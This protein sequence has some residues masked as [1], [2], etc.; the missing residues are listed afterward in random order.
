MD[1]LAKE[2]VELVFKVF[3]LNS[4]NYFEKIWEMRRGD[5]QV[6]DMIGWPMFRVDTKIT[7]IAKSKRPILLAPAGT[8]MHVVS[9]I[10][11]QDTIAVVAELGK[12]RYVRESPDTAI[13]AMQQKI[14]AEIGEFALRDFHSRLTNALVFKTRNVKQDLEESMFGLFSAKKNFSL[15]RFLSD[16]TGKLEMTVMAE[17]WPDLVPVVESNVEWLPLELFDTGEILPAADQLGHMSKSMYAYLPPNKYSLELIDPEETAYLWLATTFKRIHVYDYLIAIKRFPHADYDYRDSWNAYLRVIP[18]LRTRLTLHTKQGAAIVARC[19]TREYT[20]VITRYVTPS[21]DEWNFILARL[22]LEKNVELTGND[23]TRFLTQ[24]DM[25]DMEG[26]AIEIENMAENPRRIQRSDKIKVMASKLQIPEW[27]VR[28]GVI[29]FCGVPFILY[30]IMTMPNAIEPEEKARIFYAAPGEKYAVID[31]I[32]YRGPQLREVF[33]NWTGDPILLGA[34]VAI[35]PD[36]KNVV[37]NR[38]TDLWDFIIKYACEGKTSASDK[39]PDNVRI[40]ENYMR[41]CCPQVSIYAPPYALMHMCSTVMTGEGGRGYIPIDTFTG[42]TDPK[43]E[44]ADRLVHDG[45]STLEPA[46]DMPANRPELFGSLG[47]YVFLSNVEQ[48]TPVATLEDAAK[49]ERTYRMQTDEGTGVISGEH[50]FMF[51][52]LII[53]SNSPIL[54]PGT[55]SIK[56]EYDSYVKA[57]DPFWPKTPHI[58]SDFVFKPDWM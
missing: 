51:A 20:D 44:I 8:K 38:N 4:T 50:G 31:S 34:I 42:N 25:M 36:I 15:L 45:R 7:T 13:V 30:W 24:F 46:T 27:E 47:T 39:R 11:Y 16:R 18:A 37:H 48:N 40:P 55:T 57:R 19:V 29:F 49:I 12:R 56:E 23:K 22:K 10:T 21:D 33:Q 2:Y 32:S 1:A 3:E 26:M 5:I 17:P 28:D 9:R 43:A 58:T 54:V 35:L 41:L 14:L 53:T 6:I 52:S